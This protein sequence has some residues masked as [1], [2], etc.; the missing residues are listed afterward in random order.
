MKKFL[1]AICLIVVFGGLIVLS[2][3]TILHQAG[4][5]PEYRGPSVDL[6][7]K[8]ALVITTSHA[9]LAAPGETD[10]PATGVFGSEMTHP[11]YTFLD[12]GM[13]VDIA[14]IRGGE[15]PVDPSSFYFMVKTPE[16]ERYLNDPVAQAKV[17]NSI[18]IAEVD[19]DEYDIY[20]NQLFVWDNQKQCIV[21]AYRVGKGKEILRRYGMKGFYLQSLFRM[22]RRFLPTLRQSLE[23]GRSFTSHAE[24]LRKI[25]ALTTGGI[26]DALTR[27]FADRPFVEVS[28]GDL[29][30]LPS[31]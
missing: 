22:N 5:H 13:D 14:S 11:Y 30:D 27:H 25:H 12:G 29:S 19:I 3:P 15:I 10:G 28:A 24:L 21:G 20:Y 17:K 6:P 4:L 2:L 31:Q 23:L 8:R 18:P 26:R 7:G 16:D 1:A 9:V